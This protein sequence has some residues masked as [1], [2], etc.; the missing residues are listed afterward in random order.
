MTNPEIRVID[1]DGKQIGIMNIK[2]A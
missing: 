1:P 2:E